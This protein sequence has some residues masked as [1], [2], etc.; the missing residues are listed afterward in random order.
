MVEISDE[1]ILR[2]AAHILAVGS[3]PPEEDSNNQRI[4]GRLIHVIVKRP[5]AS[6][7]L[8]RCLSDCAEYMRRKGHNGHFAVAKIYA[9]SRRPSKN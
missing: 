6:P 2:M 4:I 8:L 9:E 3:V 1:M 7:Q 5:E